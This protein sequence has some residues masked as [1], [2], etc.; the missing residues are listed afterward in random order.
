MELALWPAC[1]SAN[2]RGGDY[3]WHTDSRGRRE[4]G[5]SSP[6]AVALSGK[7]VRA[8]PAGSCVGWHLCAVLRTLSTS[9]RKQILV[10]PGLGFSGIFESLALDVQELQRAP[11]LE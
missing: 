8:R 11:K 9:P 5:R 2:V 6:T 4:V 3:S 10:L 1:H 7:R